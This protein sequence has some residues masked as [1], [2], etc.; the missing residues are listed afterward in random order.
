ML[1]ELINY[2]DIIENSGMLISE[3]NVEKPW[4]GYIRIDNSSLKLF[5][6]TFDLK[7]PDDFTEFKQEVS[8]KL[9]FVLPKQRLSWQYHLRRSEV[10]K[11]L[12]GPVGYSRSKDD[13]LGSDLRME[14]GDQVIF[15][16]SE[17]HRLFGMDVVG[18]IAELWIH[19][20][21]TF[22]SDENDIVRVSDDYNR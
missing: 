11:V 22:L 19:S 20:D 2:L 7:L 12:E 13:N 9:L 10:W 16:K 3:I 8:P 18:I 4:G 21:S 6:S 1:R 15:S 17:R 14:K 5:I